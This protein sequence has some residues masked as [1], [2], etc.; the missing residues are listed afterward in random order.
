M[1]ATG[2]DNGTA[3]EGRAWIATQM[4][5]ARIFRRDPKPIRASSEAQLRYAEDVRRQA[6]ASLKTKG[7]G[8]QTRDQF[9]M[10]RRARVL[11][12]GMI[13]VKDDARAILDTGKAE[14][15]SQA[16]GRAY[17]ALKAKGGRS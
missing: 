7:P 6:I 9:R 2:Q 3:T 12:A 5:K 17:D 8:A 15:A 16:F 1:D 14:L 13:S 10:I 4:K 11:A